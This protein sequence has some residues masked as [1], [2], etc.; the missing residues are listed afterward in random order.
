MTTPIGPIAAITPLSSVTATGAT[1]APAAGSTSG[2]DFAAALG[3]GLDA[4]NGSQATADGLAVQAATGQLVDPA[5][6][7]IAATQ[8]ALMTQMAT[9]LESK[10]VTA[11][12]TIM[13]M[14]A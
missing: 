11:F 7:T 13:G 5:Q 6:Y 1:S 4:V 3:R 2:A 12:N 14:Q 10:A 9:T 8:A